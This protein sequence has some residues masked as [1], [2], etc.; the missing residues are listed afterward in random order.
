MATALIGPA[1]QIAAANPELAKMAVNAAA[2]TNPELVESA[3]T[4]AT[5]P[6]VENAVTATTPTELNPAVTATT[7]PSVENAVATPS[8][9]VVSEKPTFF[10][11]MKEKAT[12]AVRSL[13]P[14]INCQDVTGREISNAADKATDQFAESVKENLTTEGSNLNRQI[15][16]LVTKTLQSE[17]A[18]PESKQQLQKIILL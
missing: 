7:P 1:L 10:Q 13:M 12:N 16:D 6:S 8:S 4:A 17:F 18:K 9:S 15:D 2:V 3:V 11:N 5:P 14:S